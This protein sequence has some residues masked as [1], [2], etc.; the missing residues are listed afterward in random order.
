MKIILYTLMITLSL[1]LSTT[2]I[3]ANTA[4]AATA[5]TN[6]SVVSASQ[7]APAQ[8]DSI[9]SIKSW[10]A[11]PNVA[12]LILLI[13]VYG[14]FFEFF[15]PGLIVPGLIGLVCIV[16][17]LYAFQSLPT[18]YVGL[19]L[20][21]LGMA[22]IVFELL[23]SSFGV[24]GLGG[25]IAFVTGSILLLDINS[26]G[27]QIAWSLVMIMTVFT[28]IFFFIVVKL[29]TNSMRQKIISGKEA[30]IGSD[31]EVV[32]F[33]NNQGTVRIGGETWNATCNHPLIAGQKIRVTHLKG[34]SLTVKPID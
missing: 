15:S 8:P 6:Q 26:P 18:N 17:A 31:G 1:L 12:Y 30:M 2:A 33:E 23:I 7:I 5:L 28:V 24:L 32:T 16:V 10:L 27:Y 22:F 9:A 11:N 20:L 19:A 14:L 34:L 13:G 4:N 25:I 3:A 21:V 29:A